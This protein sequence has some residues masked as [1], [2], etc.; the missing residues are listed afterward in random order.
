MI[1]PAHYSAR[2]PYRYMSKLAL[3]GGNISD[4]VP[5]NAAGNMRLLF[6]PNLNSSMV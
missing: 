6:F 4:S 5:V 1:D 2:F 3:F